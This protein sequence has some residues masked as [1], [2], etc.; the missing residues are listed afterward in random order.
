VRNSLAF[1]FDMDGV[2]IDSTAVHTLAWERYLAE[3]DIEVPYI[4]SRM[5]GKHNDRIVREFFSDHNMTDAAVALHGSR[6]EA[7]Y[8][9]LME[10]VFVE[11]LV[12]GVLAFV[13]RN[14]GTPMGVVSNAESANVEFVLHLAG[15]EDCFSAVLNGNQ[16]KRP[17]PAPDI[18]VEAARIL[19]V[20]PARCIVFEDSQ[21]GVEAAR[22]A[23]MRVVGV[24]TTLTGFDNVEI[25][26]RNFHQPELDVW[27]KSISHQY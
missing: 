5:L 23:G 2:I 14:A 11:R 22:S 13:R 4:E 15:I 21:T 19:G 20:D 1:L 24:L 8:R 3:H 25:S 18:Y 26:I 16:V 10:P 7:L 12:P 27:L 17:K 6:K 9:E